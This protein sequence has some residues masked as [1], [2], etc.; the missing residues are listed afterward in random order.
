MTKQ[1]I[2]VDSAVQD[3]QTLIQDTSGAQIVILNENSHAIEQITTALAN[4]SDIKSIHILSHGTPGSLNI[5]SET[6]NNQNLPLFSNEIQQWGKALAKNADILLYGCEVAATEIGLQFIQNLHQLTGANIAASNNKTGNQAL[7]GDWELEVKLGEIETQSLNVP[8][9]SYTLAPTGAADNKALLVSATPT[10]T[11]IDVLA[12]DTGT[13]R[14]SVQSIAT[15][16]TNGTA[17][18]NDWIYVGGDFRNIGGTRRNRIARLNSDGTV[19]PTFNPNVL[20]ITGFAGNETVF[21][22]VLDSSGNPYISGSFNE[23]GTISRNG[24]AKLN[25]VTGAPDP[26]FNPNTNVFQCFVL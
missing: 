14:L 4:Q 5:G 16:P 25:P 21:S 24:V 15:A 26:I 3:Y 18:I 23:V 1:I 9:Y 10:T 6:L 13:G 2:F 17:I 22:I 20:N 19:D 11:K 8:N 7:G 12:N